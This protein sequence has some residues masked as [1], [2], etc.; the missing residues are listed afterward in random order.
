MSSAGL[1]WMVFGAFVVASL[2]VAAVGAVRCI[3]AA[4]VLR[5][6]MERY[7]DLPIAR[8]VAATQRRLELTQAHLAE[9]DAL[10]DQARAALASMQ[11]SLGE[12]LAG[13]GAAFTLFARAADDLRAVRSSFGRGSTAT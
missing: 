13:F 3:R 5:R 11:M 2:V 1:G 7:K 8:A 6:H 9:A 4:G 12:L 10:V